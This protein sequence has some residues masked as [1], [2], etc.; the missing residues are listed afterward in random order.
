MATQL[1]IIRKETRQNGWY[2]GV[3]DGD[4]RESFLIKFIN[5]PDGTQYIC[6]YR[7]VSRE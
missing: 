6:I 1:R 7:L 3:G 4:V 5:K 2:S